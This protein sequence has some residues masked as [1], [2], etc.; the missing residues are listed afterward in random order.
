MTRTDE[1]I[2]Q[3]LLPTFKITYVIRIVTQNIYLER[4]IENIS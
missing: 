1:S 4:G 3:I 2:R